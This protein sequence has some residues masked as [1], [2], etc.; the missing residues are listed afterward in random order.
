MTTPVNWEV[1][2]TSFTEP[3]CT[4]N[5]QVQGKTFVPVFAPGKQVF[6]CVGPDARNPVPVTPPAGTPGA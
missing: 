4:A 6:V 5:V 1:S 2:H 3:N